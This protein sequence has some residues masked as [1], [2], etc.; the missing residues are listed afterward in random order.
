MRFVNPSSELLLSDF[1]LYPGEP[2]CAD[3][4]SFI[5]RCGKICYKS[6]CSNTQ[7]GS[8]DFVKRLIKNK[9]FAMLEHVNFVFEVSESLFKAI[10]A[11]RYFSSDEAVRTRSFGDEPLALCLDKAV[12][13]HTSSTHLSCNKD[14]FLVSGNVRALN[15]SRCLPLLQELSMYYPTL[16]YSLGVLLKNPDLCM[17]GAR[18][19][20]PV[21]MVRVEELPEL[22][23]VEFIAHSY[24]TYHVVTDRGV[25]HEIVRHRLFSFAQES[26]R[27][28][29]YSKDKFGNELTFITPTGFSSLSGTA[30]CL[31]KNSYRQAENTYLRLVEQ[32]NLTPQQARAVL[33]NGIKTER[34][35]T[36]NLIEWKHFFDLRYRGTTGAPHPDMKVL[37]SLMLPDYMDK[38]T[39]NGFNP[40]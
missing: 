1:A 8:E 27:Y 11:H 39:D 28:C 29:N 9:H 17:K 19:C 26:T 40:M 20:Y 25:S 23:E 38:Y 33:P 21:E 16:A 15:D 3:A 7:E 18:S 35:I 14:R 31:L 13:L 32:C 10:N 2:Y 12:F 34:C 6:S 22:S 37:S 24:L 5:E 30:Q 36:G 4:Y